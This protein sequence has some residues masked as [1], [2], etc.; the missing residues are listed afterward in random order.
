MY[1]EP[2]KMLDQATYVTTTNRRSAAI[3]AN[4]DPVQPGAISPMASV[5]IP[6][7]QHF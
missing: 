3:T 5:D 6:V 1:T 2:H 4:G 7:R